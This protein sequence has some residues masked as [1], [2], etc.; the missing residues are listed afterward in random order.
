MHTPIKIAPGH[1][2]ISIQ[3]SNEKRSSSTKETRLRQTYDVR[4]LNG[5]SGGP[6]F[7]YERL[8]TLMHLQDCEWGYQ[9]LSATDPKRERYSECLIIFER[10]PPR[11]PSISFDFLFS[12]AYRPC[13]QRERK[14]ETGLYPSNS[15]LRYSPVDDDDF[16]HPTTCVHLRCSSFSIFTLQTHETLKLKN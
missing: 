9:Y 11:I 7:F 1:S 4:H 2:C 12:S 8:E 6:F 13:G 15:F 16:E 14:R 10:D 3:P 5:D